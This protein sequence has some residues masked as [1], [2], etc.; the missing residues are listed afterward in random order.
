MFVFF[1]KMSFDVSIDVLYP[2]C[3]CLNPTSNCLRSVVCPYP[4]KVSG[5]AGGGGFPKIIGDFFTL[6]V[7]TLDL[8]HLRMHV[9]CLLF[10][11]H[12]F[13]KVLR[14]NVIKYNMSCINVV[15]VSNLLFISD[16]IL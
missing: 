6:L 9:V 3:L 1:R 12:I 2:H 11:I 4:S 7:L 16:S 10:A 14:N 8:C 13:P 15:S 5:G